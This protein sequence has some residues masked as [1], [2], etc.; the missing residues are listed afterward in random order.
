MANEIVKYE[1]ELNTI[2]LRKFTPVEMNLFF[3]IVSRMREKGDQKILFTFDQ[4]K[5][6]SAYKQ[7]SGES[8]VKDLTRT[9]DHLMDLRF[10][11]RSNGGLTVERF[12]MFTDF[13]IHGEA[14]EPYVNIRVHE[15]ALPLLNN[16]E[17]WVRYSLEE[18]RELNSSYAK[19][20]FRLLKQY[21]TQ[22]WAEFTK[23]VFFELL[24]IPH[25]YH[26]NM[27]EIDR[28][29]LRPIKEE[30]TPLFKGLTIRKKYGK[31]R[32]KPVIGYR[33]TWKAEK[34][35]E[36]HFSKGEQVELRTKLFNIEHNGEL[37]Q[38]EKWRAKDRALGLR[39]GTHEADA[40]AHLAAEVRHR[41]EQLNQQA[42]LGDLSN[43]FQ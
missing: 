21:R 40:K 27:G 31:G 35:D 26:K 9:Y 39:L 22:G 33:F 37:T 28:R 16:L 43:M 13:E 34:N 1:P 3:S 32:G 4:L 14:E 29:V 2:P 15:K 42:L 30:L 20:M 36:N 8:F 18:F 5:D 11:K 7:T 23:D 24:D 12:V 10:G 17:T 25:S 38:E 19:T 41:Q 6:L